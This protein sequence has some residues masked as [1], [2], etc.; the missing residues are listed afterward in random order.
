MGVTSLLKFVQKACRQT[1][2]HIFSG[3]TVAIDVSCLLYKGLYNGDVISYIQTYVDLLTRLKCIIVLVFDGKAPA[4]KSEVLKRRREYEIIRSKRIKKEKNNKF[5]DDD[6]E[7][8]HKEKKINV[9]IV[10]KD[11]IQNVKRFFESYENVIIIQSPEEADSQ[12]AYLSIEGLV[13]IIVTDDSDLIVYGCSQIVFKMTPFGKCVLYEYKNLDLKLD[14]PV[15]KWACILAGC[16]YLPGGYKGLGL[17]K[18]INRLKNLQPKPPYDEVELRK[19][20]YFFNVDESF[21]QQFL[22]A[23]KTFNEAKIYD[24]ENNVI[25]DFLF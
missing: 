19:T 7:F 24:P 21:I 11:V 10:T 25:K 5:G 1:F 8:F 2:I 6:E 12:L 23:E 16:D 13:D 4:S 20:L 9:P 14:F 22:L 3:K 18:A 17:V 15:F